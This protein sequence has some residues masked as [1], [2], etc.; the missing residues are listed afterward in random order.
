[1]FVCALRGGV[2][3]VENIARIRTVL[4]RVAG[5]V[6]VPRLRRDKC[7]TEFGIVDG[8]GGCLALRKGL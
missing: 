5:T 6:R 8:L 1:M 3:G 4:R 2:R 7:W